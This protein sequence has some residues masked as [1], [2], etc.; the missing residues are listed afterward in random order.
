MFLA[1]CKLVLCFISKLGGHFKHHTLY[2]NHMAV[3]I[4]Q[5]LIFEFGTHLERV[6]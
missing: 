6:V 1:S 5:G 4:L 3:L 2:S